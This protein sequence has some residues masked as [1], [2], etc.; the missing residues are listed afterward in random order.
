M[1]GKLNKKIG[2]KKKESVSVLSINYSE[3]K[4]LEYIGVAT[5]N[6]ARTATDANADDIAK[7]ATTITSNSSNTFFDIQRAFIL[8]DL[9]SVIQD[10]LTCE[11]N[12]VT[13]G[14]TNPDIYV[15]AS[16]ITSTP[17][18]ADYDN[19]T[20]LIS[21]SNNQIADTNKLIFNGAGISY[22]NANKGSV[23]GICLKNKIYDSLNVEPPTD[24]AL[25]NQLDTA[26][27]ITLDF[28]Y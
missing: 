12:Y 6:E 4:T 27:P 11:L 3:F 10:V 28:T 2:G 7:P 23:I 24:T 19:Y 25:I 14:D 13:Y 1:Y 8:F 20:T 17:L 16:G 21:S 15:Y 9:S 26:Q 22:I 5:W 18:L